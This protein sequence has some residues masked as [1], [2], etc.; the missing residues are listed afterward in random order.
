MTIR[1]LVVAGALCF[2]ELST[3]VVVGQVTQ[4]S[5][6]DQA[7]KPYS[8]F[9]ELAQLKRTNP[10]E[11]DRQFERLVLE[12]QMS[13][14]KFG[15]GTRFTGELDNLTKGALREYQTYTGLP[16][17]G[18]LDEPTWLAIG[19][20]EETAGYGTNRTAFLPRFY[21]FDGDS[22][23]HASGAWFEDGVA[24]ADT[25]VQIECDK[26]HSYCVEAW[27][28]LGLLNI[29][30]YD[31]SRWDDVEIIAESILLCGRG[32][33]KISLQARSVIHIGVSD[34]T[35]PGC[36]GPGQKPKVSV[37]RLGDGEEWLIKQIEADAAAKRKVIRI[38]KAVHAKTSIFGD[39]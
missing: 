7:E 15:Y 17:S 21:F 6:S 9:P 12:T 22:Y 13:L 1:L 25:G 3:V 29:E 23:F 18:E 24:G 38:P 33:L 28:V 10:K 31:I 16:A 20:D 30:S 32:T 27:S 39:E 19:H 36:L 8:P 2:S 37:V 14:A 11:Y 26:S 35:K 4:P 34:G 5:P